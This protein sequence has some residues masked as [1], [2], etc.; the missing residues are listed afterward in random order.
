MGIS[1]EEWIETYGH[2]GPVEDL[3]HITLYRDPQNPKKLRITY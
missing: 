3:I 1:K 2:D